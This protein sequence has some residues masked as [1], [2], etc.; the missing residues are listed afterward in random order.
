MTDVYKKYDD[1][2]FRSTTSKKY[3]EDN[4]RQSGVPY[5]LYMALHV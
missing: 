5:F 1:T 2:S 3:K 4:G